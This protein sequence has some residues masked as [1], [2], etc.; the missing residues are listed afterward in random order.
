[1]RKHFNVRTHYLLDSADSRVL[2]QLLDAHLLA[3]ARLVV[4]HHGEHGR[5]TGVVGTIE[6]VETGRVAEDGEP[7]PADEFLN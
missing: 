4:A 6:D 3:H 1:M 2:R 5:V 7:D